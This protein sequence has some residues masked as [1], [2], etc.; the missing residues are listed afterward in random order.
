LPRNRRN[1]VRIVFLKVLLPLVIMVGSIIAFVILQVDGTV[2][3]FL[4]RQT[5]FGMILVV[6]ALNFV[7]FAFICMLMMMWTSIRDDL[8]RNGKR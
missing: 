1:I 5:M 4:D 3:E 6:L 2:R 7:G 8:L